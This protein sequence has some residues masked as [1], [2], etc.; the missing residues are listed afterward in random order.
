MPRAASGLGRRFQGF[1]ID[2]F[3]FA[4][5]IADPGMP[6]RASILD[7]FFLGTAEKLVQVFLDL[8]PV[9][10]LAVEALLEQLVPIVVIAFAV[11]AHGTIPSTLIPETRTASHRRNQGQGGPPG[12]RHR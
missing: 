1:A 12:I 8:V 9:D 2:A 4:I 5:E 7:L 11:V 10:G 6:F 3:V